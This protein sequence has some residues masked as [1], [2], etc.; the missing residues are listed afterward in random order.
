MSGIDLGRQTVPGLRRKSD[1]D[2]YLR[3]MQVRP[4]CR[5][6]DEIGMV[7][8][9]AWYKIDDNAWYKTGDTVWYMSED[10]G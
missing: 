7:E 1:Y 3:P 10:I 8:D 5:W 6:L 2:N 9:H 4:G